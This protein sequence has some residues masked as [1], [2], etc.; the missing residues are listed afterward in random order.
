CVLNGNPQPPPHPAVA[1]D[2]GCQSPPYTRLLLP[3][4]AAGHVPLA[5]TM[6]GFRVPDPAS[7]L[8][9]VVLPPSNSFFHYRT[10]TIYYF[11]DIFHTF[12]LSYE[13]PSSNS[14]NQNKRRGTCHRPSFTGSFSGCRGGICRPK[15]GTS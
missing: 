5:A 9:V 15:K 6:P 1:R 3:S 7:I 2:T 13:P 12:A 14:V 8:R 4:P 10:H 11:Y